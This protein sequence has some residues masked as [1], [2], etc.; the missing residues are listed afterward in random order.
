MWECG[1]SMLESR[2]MLSLHWINVILRMLS[3]LK[4][5]FMVYCTI[6][7]FLLYCR[8][9]GQFTPS[10][11][12]CPETYIWTPIEQC[13]PKLNENKYSRFHADPSQGIYH[14]RLIKSGQSNF[15]HNSNDCKIFLLI[16]KLSPLWT[17]AENLLC[18]CIWPVLR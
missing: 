17:G 9:K 5:L 8:Y 12:L 18:L 7:C 11:L 14:K 1:L 4:I 10:Y 16:Y 15:L 13:V 3:S 2:P 6:V